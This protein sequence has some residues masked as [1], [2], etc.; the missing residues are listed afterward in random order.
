MP[1]WTAPLSILFW[2]ASWSIRLGMLPIVI[3]RHRAPEAMAWL[4]VIFFEPII[5]V[6]VY[7]LVGRAPLARSRLA[8]HRAVIDALETPERL[9]PMQRY[10]VPFSRIPLYRRD[11]VTLAARIGRM[12]LLGGNS[13]ELIEETDAVIDR[14]IADLDAAQ[15][16]ADLLFYIYRDDATGRRLGEALA[17][18]AAR[19]VKVRLLLDS[20]GS[21]RMLGTLAPTLRRSGVLVREALP[22]NPWRKVFARI[23]IRNHRKLAVIDGVLAYTGSQNIADADYGHGHIGAW[24]DLTVRMTGPAVGQVAIIFLED[25]AFETREPIPPI[26][27]TAPP[28]PTGDVPVQTVA[29]GPGARNEALRDLMV[30]AVHEADERIIMTTPYLVPDDSFLLALRL[31]AMGGLTVDVIVPA[32]GNHGLVNAAAS[33]F[34]DELLGAGVRIH[35]HKVGLLHAK[36][37]TVDNSIAMIGSGNFDRRSFSLNFEL[38][39]LLFGPDLTHQLIAVQERYMSESTRLDPERWRERS[40]AQ[41]FIQRS[42]RLFGPLL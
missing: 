13:V 6:V 5:G 4:A 29:S 36:T 17:R 24:R 11:F 22:V 10:A 8:R 42:A 7:T 28:E 35:L 40:A 26:S 33:S 19:G 23:D 3:M 39:L 31:A 15:S 1:D 34:Y 30:D 14:L 18:A 12:P 20:V 38:N 41:R 37:L 2:L 32:K 9:A 25:W 16:S 21:S 27:A